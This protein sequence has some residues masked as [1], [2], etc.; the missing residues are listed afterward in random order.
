MLRHFLG[1]ALLLVLMFASTATA[2]SATHTMTRTDGLQRY[3]GTIQ[4]SVD[5]I[6][7]QLQNLQVGDTVYAQLRVTNNVSPRLLIADSALTNLF[8]D[9][10]DNKLA[11]TVTKAGDY[12]L[13]LLAMSGSGSYTLHVGINEEV[14]Q[15]R[16]G[17][18]LFIGEPDTPPIAN[19]IIQ[20]FA[21]EF[22]DNEE[23]IIVDLTDLQVGD[24]IYVYASGIGFVD[25]Y[26]YILD[27]REL[28]VF[29]EDDNSGGGFNSALSFEVTEAGDYKVGLITIDSVGSYRMVVGVNTPAV[30][31]SANDASVAAL[32]EGSTFVCDNAEFGDRPALSGIVKTIEGDT[33]AIHYTNTGRDAA[34]DEYAAVLAEA[35]QRSLNVQFNDL[36]WARPPDDCGEGG[37]S[38]L[39]VYIQ[40][41]SRVRAS[42][43]ARRENIVGDNPYTDTP[44]YYA[45]YSFLIIDNDMGGERSQ[46]AALDLLRTTAAHEVHHNIQFG[47]DVNDRYFGIYEAG[48]SW[49]E[50]LV[51]PALT[52]GYARVDDVFDNP[53]YCI[54]YEDS[55]DL[56]VYGEWLMIDSF[57]RDLGMGTY[58]YVWEFMARSE[59]IQGFYDALADLGTSPQEVIL[60]TAVRNLLKDYALAKEFNTEVAIE[61]TS[62]GVGFISPRRDGVHQLSVDYVELRGRGRYTY[63]LVDADNLEMYIVGIDRTNGTARLYELGSGGTVD[64]REYTHS[65]LIVLNTDVH[66]NSESC[67]FRDWAIQVFSGVEDPLSTPTDE[68]WDASQFVQP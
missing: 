38:R 30:L 14:P 25:T 62:N 61:A 42:G 55:N 60:R 11:F 23:E 35:I 46:Q 20:E 9:T 57:V 31:D 12:A 37:D 1:M 52:N 8:T 4:Q 33:Y 50:T 27:D 21:G 53:D 51:Y 24:I 18:L 3:E 36:G 44:E 66:Q 15:S 48:A 28:D 17:E 49:I 32:P 59:G 29:A 7:I 58:R 56:R 10:S 47:Y 45:A 68:I 6:V 43:I 2:Q 41:I 67:E 64:T 5:E 65:Y 19:G 13:G 39:D 16:A 40:D 22:L 34:S 54:G 63:S 26:V